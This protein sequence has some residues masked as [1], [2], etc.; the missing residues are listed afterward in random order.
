MWIKAFLSP[1]LQE[2]E[3]EC[4]KTPDIDY[5]TECMNASEETNVQASIFE[6]I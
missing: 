3:I 1:N 6:P 5:V 2:L 4:S